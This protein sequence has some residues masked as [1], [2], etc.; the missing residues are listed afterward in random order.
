MAARHIH[1]AGFI[2]IAGAGTFGSPDEAAEAWRAAVGQSADSAVPSAVDAD[3][4]MFLAAC[5]QSE[6]VRRGSRTAFPDGQLA[7][8]PDDGWM[9]S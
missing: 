5:V 9:T 6:S 4:L 3:A 2:T 8:G 7:T 1:G